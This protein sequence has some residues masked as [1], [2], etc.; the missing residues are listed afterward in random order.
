[1]IYLRN[2]LKTKIKNIKGFKMLIIRKITHRKNSLNRKLQQP[3]EVVNLCKFLIVRGFSG[4]GAHN[5]KTCERNA[6]V[7][8]TEQKIEL[9]PFE[10]INLTI[11]QTKIKLHKKCR[12]A[13]RIQNVC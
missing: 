12:L 3:F 1:M 4:F 13:Y 5:I 11:Q 2:I 6:V 10:K 8:N 9:K 7:A